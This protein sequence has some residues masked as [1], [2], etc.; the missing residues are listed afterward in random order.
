LSSRLTLT[1][2]HIVS[3]LIP[4]LSATSRHA[5]PACPARHRAGHARAAQ[6]ARA[7]PRD[8]SSVQA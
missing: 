5:R 7:S 6:L 3:L 1:Q 8:T 4:K 2:L